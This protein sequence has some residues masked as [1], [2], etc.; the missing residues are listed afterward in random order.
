M[1]SG[2]FATEAQSSQSPSISPQTIR[3]LWLCASVAKSSGV[4]LRLLCLFVANRFEDRTRFAKKMRTAEDLVKDSAK[5]CVLRGMNQPSAL[6][7]PSSGEAILDTLDTIN[8]VLHMKTT[9]MIDDSVLKMA[10]QAA[11]NRDTTMSELVNQSLRAFLHG[12]S[13]LPSESRAFSLPVYGQ[14]G[15]AGTGVSPATLAELRD[16][17]R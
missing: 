3:P 1:I 14:T 10:K 7:P 6:C 11:A 5:S 8:K 16:D 13:N 17:G 12:K 15:L 9:L 2:G 4:F